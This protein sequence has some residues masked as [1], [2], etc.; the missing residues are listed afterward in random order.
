M[1]YVVVMKY[2]VG[3]PLLIHIELSWRSQSFKNWGV[4][5]RSF[6]YRLHS[7]VFKGNL[8]KPHKWHVHTTLWQP[9]PP[10]LKLSSA[11]IFHLLGSLCS[12]FF[13]NTD[14][15]YIMIFGFLMYA[16]MFMN[17]LPPAGGPNC[18]LSMLSWWGF[19]CFCYFLQTVLHPKISHNHLLCNPLHFIT[20]NC[21]LTSLHAEW[22]QQLIQCN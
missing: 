17:P 2:L 15:T 1:I 10:S 3:F 13:T 6:V 12:K 14:K 9:P 21:S 5:V 20:H 11:G 16:E 7:P 18:W 8:H 22:H 19:L 4:R